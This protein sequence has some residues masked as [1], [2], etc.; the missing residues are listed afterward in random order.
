MHKKSRKPRTADVQFRINRAEPLIIVQVMVNDRG[1]FRF[2]IDTGASMTIISPGAAKRAGISSSGVNAKARGAG[3]H[4]DATVIKIRSLRLGTLLHTNLPAAIVSLA[5]LNRT[6]RL[7][8][9]GIL[10]YN[11]LRR[12]RVTIDYPRRT[13]SFGQSK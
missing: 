11:L 13:L 6:P 10:G 5:M 3:G 9:D 12:Y 8:L 7:K 2:V 4:L 1:P